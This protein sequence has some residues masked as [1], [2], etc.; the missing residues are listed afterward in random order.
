MNK[1]L[2][3]KYIV[4]SDYLGNGYCWIPTGCDTLKEAK[5]IG[6]YLTDYVITKKVDYT[7][8]EVE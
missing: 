5:T 4:W 8:Q 7:V 3:K 2:E 1:E 6:E